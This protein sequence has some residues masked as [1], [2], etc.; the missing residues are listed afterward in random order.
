MQLTTP[1]RLGYLFLAI[2]SCLTETSF[3]NGQKPSEGL[4]LYYWNQQWGGRFFENLGDVLSQKLVERIVG[5]PVRIYKLGQKPEKKLL[6][7][8][9]LLSFARDHDVIWGTGV[10]GKVTKK[11]DFKF[12]TLDVRA[13]R[14]P[15]TRK[16]LWDNFRIK[17]PEIYGDPALLIP[18]F[19]PEFTKKKKPKY[20]YIIIPHYSEEHLF[21]KDEW[22][23]IVYSTEPW[24]EVLS[25]ILNSRFVISSSLHGIIVAEAYGIPARLLV[26]SKNEPLFKYYDYYLGT[27]RPYFQYASSVDEALEM[28][29]EP[30]FECDLKQLY[31]AFPFEYWPNAKFKKIK[32]K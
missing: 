30:A 26:I 8:G 28:G 21:P 22:Q 7:I 4:P 17:C 2:M 15:L 1:N 11:K 23:N 18:Y 20:D 27:N 14:G 13:V 16:F 10:N 12:T 25:K 29:G 3:A 19:F 24:Y 9:S 6:A 31:E 5:A 32:F